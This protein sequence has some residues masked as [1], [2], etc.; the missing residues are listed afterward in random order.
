MN[1]DLLA[2]GIHSG[3]GPPEGLSAA[4]QPAISNEDFTGKRGQ[5]SLLYAGDDLAA[6][7]LLLVGL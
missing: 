1:A 7:R 5:T 4:A 2:V 3:E 6:R